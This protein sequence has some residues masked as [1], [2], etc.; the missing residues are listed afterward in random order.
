MAGVWG[1]QGR[2]LWQRDATMGWR[3][4]APWLVG[5]GY[6]IAADSSASWRLA[7]LTQQSKSTIWRSSSELF[8]GDASLTSG[9]RRPS[10]SSRRLI[11]AIGPGVNE[12]AATKGGKAVP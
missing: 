1:G 3:A 8:H 9:T 7:I 12:R 10:G 4:V 11:L 5:D 2:L 6:L